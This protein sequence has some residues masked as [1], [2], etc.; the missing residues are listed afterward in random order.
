MENHV[1]GNR[2]PDARACWRARILAR[3]ES[4]VLASVLPDRAETLRTPQNL[5]ELLSCGATRA[6]TELNEKRFGA[7]HF[8]EKVTFQGHFFEPVS[9]D[10]E[11]YIRNLARRSASRS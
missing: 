2:V 4:G 9:P 3:A 11:F 1:R 8:L 6:P 10:G 7:I 5:I